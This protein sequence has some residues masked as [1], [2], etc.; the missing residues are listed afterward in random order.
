M[1]LVTFIDAKSNIKTGVWGNDTVLD[2]AA[3]SRVHDKKMRQCFP[4]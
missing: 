4:Q 1:N 2:L 3:A